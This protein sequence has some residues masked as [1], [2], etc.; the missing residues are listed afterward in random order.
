MVTRSISL[1]SRVMSKRLNVEWVK[2]LNE[3]RK[4]DPRFDSMGQDEYVKMRQVW[5]AGAA[6]AMNALIRKT[7][8]SRTLGN[9]SLS[10]STLYEMRDECSEVVDEGIKRREREERESEEEINKRINALKERI[11]KLYDT[12]ISERL[13]EDDVENRGAAKEASADSDRFRDYASKVIEGCNIPNCEGCEALKEVMSESA[14]AKGDSVCT[15]VHTREKK[16]ILASDTPD[17]FIFGGETYS[18]KELNPELNE[19]VA[20]RTTQA[21][22]SLM[23][24]E[25]KV[26]PDWG[27][28][29]EPVRVTR[30]DEHN[31]RVEPYYCD[32]EDPDDDEEQERDL[33]EDSEFG[34]ILNEILNAIANGPPNPS[35]ISIF[36]LK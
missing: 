9:I 3:A 5:F 28:I 26:Y 7:S 2:Q 29:E 16:P 24:G 25:T 10:L 18:K 32:D 13:F 11:K 6:G 30:T 31:L 19:E 22:Q 14:P 23:I 8:T 15:M 33:N 1:E 12:P 27:P 36:R 35:G 34:K 20:W 21:Y 4:V 17:T